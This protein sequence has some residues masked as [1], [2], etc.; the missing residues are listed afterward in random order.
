MKKVTICHSLRIES[1]EPRIAP[2]TFTVT[3]TNDSGPGSLRQAIM[4]ANAATTADTILFK[5]PVDSLIVLTGGEILISDSLT[6]KGPGAGQLAISGNNASRIFKI[7]D[8]ATTL[9][10]VSISGLAFQEGNSAAGGGALY[11]K[12]NLSLMGCVFNSNGAAGS[13][14]AVKL[15]DF[16]GKLTVTATK[17]LN[18][19][20]GNN[21]GGLYVRARS[22]GA[23]KVSG[24]TFARNFA[25]SHGGGLYGRAEGS[26]DITIEKTVIANN[27]A[28]TS[29][30]GVWVSNSY[31]GADGMPKTPDDGKITIRTSIITGNQVANSSSLAGGIYLGGGNVTI[32]STTI[33]NNSAVLKGGGL[34]SAGVTDSLKLIGV[35]VISN[36][37]TD[38][39]IG[40]SGGGGLY[41]R[42]SKPVT[43]QSSLF[44]GNHTET[45]GGAIMVSNNNISG[46]TLTITATTF[47]SN[48]ALTAGGGAIRA[49]IFT[50]GTT[51]DLKM[52]ITG[53]KFLDNFA[54]GEGGAITF[55]KG[56]GLLTI[57]GSTFT[58]NRGDSGGGA[59]ATSG[60]IATL[61]KA[62]TF[63]GNVTNGDGGGLY[64]RTSST[65]D[66]MSSKFSGNS[67]SAH[68]GAM[69]LGPSS[70]AVGGRTIVGTK[71]TDNT[72]GDEG[73]GVA[74]SNATATLMLKSSTVTGNV[75]GSPG[76]G[77]LQSR[78]IPHQRHQLTDQQEHRAHRSPAPQRLT[79]QTFLVREQKRPRGYESPSTSRC[80]SYVP[81]LT[82]AALP[83]ALADASASPVTLRTRAHGRSPVLHSITPPY[84]QENSL[85]HGRRRTRRVYWRGASHC[86]GDRSAN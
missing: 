15:K 51:N 32:Q 34:V 84:E 74:V 70:G 21:G 39:T 13:G 75:A 63:T 22:S 72:A 58:G 46:A 36:F 33:S 47:S 50:G 59:V 44:V 30:G 35:K 53:S 18:N 11:C 61:I 8:A 38:T 10:T 52:T 76:R 60:G 27:F 16:Q 49:G 71:I 56:T 37:T 54:F 19:S 1:L 2:A 40:T 81:K 66:I 12:E 42:G 69:V 64:L 17:F 85:W 57:T 3:S 48:S 78:R 79:A 45:E 68:G 4:D 55:Q 41:F 80:R 5:L 62:S 23:V 31:V 29:G 20:S 28:G 83:F 26:G 82:F 86:G 77:P 6:V 43:I 24:C 25:N 73:G 67:A 65:I 14:G 9:K 7:D